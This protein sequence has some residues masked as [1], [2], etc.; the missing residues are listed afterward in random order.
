M[1]MRSAHELAEARAHE[2]E[3]KLERGLLSPFEK[4]ARIF[5][6]ESFDFIINLRAIVVRENR[7]SYDRAAYQTPI[8]VS[9]MLF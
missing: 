6:L 9:R 2:D 8:E 4:I 5:L 3:I 7:V 1:R